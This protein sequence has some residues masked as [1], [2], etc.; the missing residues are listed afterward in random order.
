CP[1][2][3]SGRARSPSAG[4][5]GSRPPARRPTG[6]QEPP[7][8]SDRRR[9]GLGAREQLGLPVADGAAVPEDGLGERERLRPWIRDGA[10][11]APVE[12]VLT[13]VLVPAADP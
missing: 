9:I 11:R 12:Q 6:W 2:R 4:G 3:R 8:S 13:Q 5:G 1:S 10:N 7:R